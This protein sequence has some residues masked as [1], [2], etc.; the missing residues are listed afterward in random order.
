MS[1]TA[2]TVLL[3]ALV[4]AVAYSFSGT[5]G[6]VDR[7]VA[8]R[9]LPISP[10]DY[11]ASRLKVA[12]TLFGLLL[13]HLPI[14][15]GPDLPGN[16]EH[17]VDGQPYIRLPRQSV[18]AP[19]RVTADDLAAFRRTCNDR[20]EA[21]RTGNSSP[22]PLDH[23][24]L[25]PLAFPLIPIILSSPLNPIKPLGGVN[26]R[27]TLRWYP[28][29]RRLLSGKAKERTTVV[30]SA[31]GNEEI[32]RAR[33]VKRGLE[34]DTVIRI[35]STSEQ[36]RAL[37]ST[38][39]DGKRAEEVLFDF[40]FT[41]L[42]AVPRRQLPLPNPVASYGSQSVA[43]AKDIKWTDDPEPLPITALHATQYGAL[44]RDYNPIHFS[45][46]LAKAFGLKR[47]VAHGYL[48]VLLACQ[49]AATAPP[50][51][52]EGAALSG[53]KRSFTKLLCHEDGACMH[54]YF[55][56]PVFVPGRPSLRW[57]ADGSRAEVY[58]VVKGEVKVLVEIQL[59]SIKSS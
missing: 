43:D 29:A 38:D 39:P 37:P 8:D 45:S 1:A 31:G 44:S 42:N 33:R 30:A 48:V 12:S 2:V 24:S 55:R 25:A 22:P 54:I 18:S 32:L 13:K 17:G 49:R 10:R 26:V 14:G 21:I 56:R 46:I 7:D 3:T 9:Y 28:G 4:A 6:A 47:R 19:F 57:S 59:E 20:F 23:L 41:S 35:V 40:T 58:E 27:S 5:R 51:E 15:R 52:G 36:M 34:W 50:K 16:L 11:F 53:A